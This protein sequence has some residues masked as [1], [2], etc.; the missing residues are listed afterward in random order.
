[1]TGLDIARQRLHNQHISLAD[2][3]QPVDVVRWMGAVQAQD[4]EGA[5][6]AVAQRTNGLS[7]ASLEQACTDG[8]ILRTH[9]MRPTW[10][11]VTPADIRWMLALTAPRILALSAYYFRQL[12]LDNVIFK[13]SNIVLGKALQ[14]GKQLTRVELISVLKKNNVAAD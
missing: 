2:F 6:W 4:Y 12:E 3:N 10:H 9:V 1:M 5:K 8:T 11:F 14:G 7:N 13:R